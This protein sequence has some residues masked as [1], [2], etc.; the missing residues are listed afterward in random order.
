MNFFENTTLWLAH[1]AIYI[2]LLWLHQRTKENN[3][4]DRVISVKLS[5]NYT[6][7]NQRKKG[8]G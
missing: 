3:E 5:T 1:S 6:Y 2:K 7:I 4:S 8:L